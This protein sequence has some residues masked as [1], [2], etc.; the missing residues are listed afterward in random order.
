MVI[1]HDLADELWEITL[2][3]NRNGAEPWVMMKDCQVFP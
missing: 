1:G 3:L 2:R